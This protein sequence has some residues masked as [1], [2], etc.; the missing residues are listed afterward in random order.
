MQTTSIE[1]LEELSTEE[2]RA[3]LTQEFE[4]IT[5]AEIDITNI[6]NIIHLLGDELG[7]PLIK[8]RVVGY[9]DCSYLHILAKM[10]QPDLIPL[11][12]KAGEDPNRLNSG[13]YTP[14]H[15]AVQSHYTKNI[16]RLLEAGASL[17][18][19]D[20][21]AKTPL[22]HAVFSK[23]VK[24]VQILLEYGADPNSK[25]CLHQTPMHVAIFKHNYYNDIQ[26]EF[27][28]SPRLEEEIFYTNE[29]ESIIIQL[30]E[31]GA[32]L[33]ACDICG[34]TCLDLAMS[35]GNTKA[36]KILLAA[37]AKVGYYQKLLKTHG[38]KFI[39]SYT[40]NYYE[41]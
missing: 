22:H 29:I 40:T 3:L 39:N 14:L 18:V 2:L 10:K 4:N 15:L 6:K 1:Q 13:Q 23:N 8:G 7:K 25:D 34:N 33:E 12:I 11:F 36:I 41:N 16:N 38:T 27:S 20:D 24:S 19:Q 32:D 37:G 30:I 5:R 17:E 21:R 35:V 28:H 31:H 9:E 26:W